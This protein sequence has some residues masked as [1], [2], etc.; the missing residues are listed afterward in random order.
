MKAILEVHLDFFV[1]GDK[2]Q[3]VALENALICNVLEQM[4]W[5]FRVNDE[6]NESTAVIRITEGQIPTVRLEQ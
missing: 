3:D 6:V 2:L 5:T 4:K 1:D